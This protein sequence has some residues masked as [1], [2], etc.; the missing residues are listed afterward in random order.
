MKYYFCSMLILS[1]L[2]LSCGKDNN[3]APPINHEVKYEV[4]TSSG[5]WFGEWIDGSNKREVMT[6]PPWNKSGW[7]TT[8]VP[9]TYPIDLTCHAT[10][11]CICK[12]TSSSPDVT[13]NVY[14]DGKLVKTE[15]N[16]W[17]K[18]VTTAV[19]KLEQ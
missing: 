10:T 6:T 3:N 9:T 1:F 14:V 16:N 2:F 5:E 15:T 17:S 13:V 19:Y 12:S 4:T 8:F 18:G 11:T 7:S